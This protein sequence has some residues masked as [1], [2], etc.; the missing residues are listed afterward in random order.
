MSRW[1]ITDQKAL[2]RTFWTTFPHLSRR[3]IPDYSGKGKM[4]CTDTRVAWCDWIDALSK[5]GVIS[6]ALAQRATL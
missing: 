3:R 4:Y 2:R 5:D 6:Q 1:Q